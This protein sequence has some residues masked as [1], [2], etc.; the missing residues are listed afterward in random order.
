MAYGGSKLAIINDIMQGSPLFNQWEALH[1]LASK[2]IMVLQFLFGF[3]T[4]S[5]LK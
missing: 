3:I 1:G 5:Q 2:A 4:L